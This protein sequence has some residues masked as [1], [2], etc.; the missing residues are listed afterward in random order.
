MKNA[1]TKERKKFESSWKKRQV[2]SKK[3]GSLIADFSIENG[4]QKMVEYFQCAESNN[5]FVILIPR[6]NLQIR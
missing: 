1:E 4:N 6:G 5:Q 3:N 2:T